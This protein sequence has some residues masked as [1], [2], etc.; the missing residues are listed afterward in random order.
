VPIQLQ[1]CEWVETSS[2]FTINDINLNETV[3]S[4]TVNPST[5]AKYGLLRNESGI[6]IRTANWLYTQDST[7]NYSCKITNPRPPCWANP[8]FVEMNYVS[9][10]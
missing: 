3:V 6:F 5:D 2:Y 4:L 7:F 1:L 8:N 10:I 9:G